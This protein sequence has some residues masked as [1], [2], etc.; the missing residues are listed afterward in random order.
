L[1]LHSNLAAGIRECEII[2]WFVEP[3]ARVEEFDKICEVQSDKAS[4]EIPSRFTGVIKK[5]HYD[6][7][8][9]AIVGK[10]LVDID[11]QED[12]T[13]DDSQ[14]M[15]A[16]ENGTHVAVSASAVKSSKL[17]QELA[18]RDLTRLAVKSGEHSTL[19][20]PAV[21]HLS[22]ELNIDISN[23]TGTGKDGRVMKEDVFRYSS[24]RDVCSG[25]ISEPTS[26]QGSTQTAPLVDNGC[27]KETKVE[28]SNIQVQMFKSM[29]RSLSIP[30]FLYADEVDFSS[31]ASL[32]H[33][34]NKSLSDPSGKDPMKLSFLPFII[35]AV[36]MA[37]FQYPILN[38]RVEIDPSTTKPSLLMRSQHNIG[39]AMDTPQ[40]LVVPVIRNVASLDILSIAAELKRLQSLANS[41][42]LTVADISG[43][44][45]T[46][47]NVG[48]IGG[49]FVSPVIVEREVAILGIGR[50][51]AV[52]AFDD[53]GDVVRK[54]VCGLSWSADHRVVDGATMARA[55]DV[56]RQFVEEP[57]RMLVHLR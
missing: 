4:V 16:Q 9:M 3:E 53:K 27:Q 46:V 14:S 11:V 25:A 1:I 8:E 54:Q 21:R 20:T 42:K 22:K 55:A 39:I 56:V 51:R 34:L 26:P 37:L 38:A 36:S 40:G 23:I 19:A 31:L 32:R 2:Q 12:V 52:P 6:N 18:K 41:G 49:T 48:S 28:L 44:T 10:P 57:D 7:G 35:K 24:A 5:L 43:G 13:E 30:H 29:T 15:T 50:V 33:R 45:I 47:S 17:S